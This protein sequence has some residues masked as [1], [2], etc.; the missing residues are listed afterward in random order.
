MLVIEQKWR[1]SATTVGWQW[2][3][4]TQQS[5]FHYQVN[6]VRTLQTERGFM[7]A[8]WITWVKGQA[9]LQI[10]LEQQ[11]FSWVLGQV[12]W[13]I[14]IR[15]G[16]IDDILVLSIITTK[17]GWLSSAIVML[18][19]NRKLWHSV[20]RRTVTITHSLKSRMSCQ[21]SQRQECFKAQ[22]SVAWSNHWLR[23]LET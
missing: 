17:I 22:G 3:I 9:I 5:L 1:N 7:V 2:F 14:V 12:P 15:R 13:T 21:T 19:K 16:M 18:K 23:G 11:G 10:G 20:D 4:Q 8:K 6:S